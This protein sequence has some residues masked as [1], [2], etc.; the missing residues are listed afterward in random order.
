MVTPMKHSFSFRIFF[1]ALAG[2]FAF[3]F[4]SL[5]AWALPSV[6]AVVFWI[7]LVLVFF[8]ALVRLPA[9]LFVAFAEL[10]VGSFGYMLFW[11]Q[12]SLSL[13]VA[14]WVVIMSVWFGKVIFE[15]VFRRRLQSQL[16]PFPARSLYIAA[17]LVFIMASIRGVLR[18]PLELVFFD[19]NNWLFFLYILPMG[20]AFSRCR[21]KGIA[22]IFFAGCAVLVFQTLALLYVFSHP[23]SFDVLQ[24]ALY[25][26]I[27][28]MRIG[29]ITFLSPSVFRIFI[30][31]QIWLV[32]AYA[33]AALLLFRHLINPFLRRKESAALFIFFTLI[34]A[35]LIASFSRSLWVGVFV[36]V[37]AT[38]LLFFVL[39][40]S[41]RKIV[42]YAG[43]IAAGA[44][45][46]YAALVG[47]ISLPPSGGGDISRALDER[48][49]VSGP[50]G[51]SRINQLKPL[52]SNIRRHPILGSGFGTAIEYQSTDPRIVAQTPGQS[53]VYKTTAFE[54][55]WLDI[56]LDMG[57]VGVGTIGVILWYIA[58]T[59]YISLARKGSI[60]E[61]A[62]IAGMAAA[63]AGIHVFTPYINH[64]LGIGIILLL[65]FLVARFNMLADGKREAP[66]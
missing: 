11:E 65:V 10:L 32:P 43:I 59:A 49:A 41:K 36:F 66:A 23:T 47:V 2:I 57:L 31:S 26:W 39:L 16:F 13:R 48:V 14:M 9:A 27:R 17:A 22:E 1:V 51:T 54:W 3:E 19:A 58:G 52:L 25:G 15:W 64:P 33:A 60:F 7:I 18:N 37:C 44:G 35:S 56:W 12:F 4:L 46:G 42:R 40:P 53:G 21:M 45:F 6:H 61:G 50:G 5:L 62:G 29:E 8:L 38:L 24:R 28:D 20:Y 34:N 30:Q 55:G 63:L